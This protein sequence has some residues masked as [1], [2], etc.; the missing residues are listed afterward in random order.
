MELTRV[1]GQSRQLAWLKSSPWNECYTGKPKLVVSTDVVY[2]N[3]IMPIPNKRIFINCFINLT[4]K[5]CKLKLLFW[6]RCAGSTLWMTTMLISR[7]TCTSWGFL[8]TPIE[9]ESTQNSHCNSR[10]RK[11]LLGSGMQSF[12]RLRIES[13]FV[14]CTNCIR[15]SFILLKI[16][17]VYIL[18]P[19]FLIS[20]ILRTVSL[21]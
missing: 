2:S 5:L 16:H 4:Q 3:Y 12:L 13:Q 19:L 17:Y 11:H 18:F 15:N 1:G 20:T 7:G 10:S 9:T 8:H 6:K 14:S 21:K